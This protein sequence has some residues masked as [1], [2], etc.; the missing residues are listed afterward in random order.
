MVT[1]VT[2]VMVTAVTA[3]KNSV[4]KPIQL[5]EIDSAY[6]RHQGPAIMGRSTDERG[7]LN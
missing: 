2:M 4:I 7:N 3:V 5:N 6:F 1:A